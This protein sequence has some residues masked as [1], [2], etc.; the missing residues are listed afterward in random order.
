[1]CKVLEETWIFEAKNNAEADERL[2]AELE[3]RGLKRLPIKWDRRIGK[4]MT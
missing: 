4:V 1:M 2:D 3:A